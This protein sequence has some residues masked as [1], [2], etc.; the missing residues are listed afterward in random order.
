VLK[1]HLIK[2]GFMKDYRCWN[3]HGEEGL[4]EAEMRDS[5]LKRE[6]PTSVEEVHN[7]VNETDILGLIDNDIMYQVVIKFHNIAHK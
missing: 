3:K 7:D 4:K 1:S 2:C 5:Y 6:V